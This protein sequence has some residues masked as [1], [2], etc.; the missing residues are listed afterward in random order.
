MTDDAQIEK[1]QR[2]DEI[3]LQNNKIELAHK[4]E[5]N[6][7]AAVEEAQL[8]LNRAIENRKAAERNAQAAC[9]IPVS[10]LL[11]LPNIE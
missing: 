11:D 1:I 5:R 2:S 3:L 10:T 7:S 4:E 9:R 8:K 6:A